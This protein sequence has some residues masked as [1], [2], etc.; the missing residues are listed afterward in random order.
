[1]K[2]ELETVR[3]RVLPDGRV[4]SEDAA[5][6]LDYSLQTLANWRWSGKGPRWTRRGGRIFYM[7]EDLKKWI[8][9]GK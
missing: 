1:M 3:V 9:N 5:R 7:I 8:A 4:R 2:M 6:F